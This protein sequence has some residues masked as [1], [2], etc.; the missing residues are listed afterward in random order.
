MPAALGMYLKPVTYVC[1]GLC[2]LPKLYFGLPLATGLKIRPAGSTGF[3]CKVQ[4]FGLRYK[5]AWAIYCFFLMLDSVLIMGVS[6][7]F[8]LGLNA[9]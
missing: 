8:T 4:I 7:G 9:E 2:V 6:S 1:M 5:S 3:P